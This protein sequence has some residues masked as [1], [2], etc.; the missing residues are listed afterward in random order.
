M[1]LRFLWQYRTLE[2]KGTYSGV[3]LDNTSF[4]S[5]LATMIKCLFI[6]RCHSHSDSVDDREWFVVPA[7]LP[8]YGNEKVLEDEIWCGEVVVQTTATFRRTHAPCGIIGRFLAFSAGKIMSSGECWQHGAHIRWQNGHDVLVC[9]T[10]VEDDGVFPGIAICVKGSTAEAMCVRKDVKETLLSLIEDDVYGYPG[11]CWP[12]F[13]DSEPVNSNEFQRVIRAYLDIKLASLN[14]ILEKVSCDS[15]RMFQAAFPSCL[16]RTEYPRLVL[17]VPDEPGQD[18]AGN[19]KEQAPESGMALR[20]ETWDRWIRLCNSGRRSFRLV[21]LC[22]HDLSAVP[23]G[24][25]GKGYPI[26][27]ATRLFKALKPL[28]QVIYTR[29]PHHWKQED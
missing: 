11:L 10:F 22:E 28:L 4:E 19:S 14:E 15:R 23:C 7:R 9:E 25:E 8:E 26:A 18:L 6:Y 16:N 2:D 27:D 3:E 29:V 20:R 5:M 12:E 17:L 24:P 13:N 21:F 1:Y